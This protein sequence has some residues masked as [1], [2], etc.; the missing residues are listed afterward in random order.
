MQTINRMALGFLLVLAAVTTV[1]GQETLRISVSDPSVNVSFQEMVENQLLISVVDHEEN[2]VLGLNE[3]DFTIKKDGRSTIVLKV[4]P[5]EMAKDVGMNYVLVVDNSF[6]MKER[7]AVEP[8]LSALEK[9]YAILRPIDTVYGIVFNKTPITIDGRPVHAKIFKSGNVSE[10]RKFFNNSFTNKLS[11]KTFLNEAMFAGIELVEKM[12]AVNNKFLVVFS[13][14]EDI[15]SGFDSAVVSEKAEGIAN[16]EA[17]AIDYMPGPDLDPFLKSF[18]EAHGGKIWKASSA[19]DL[20]PIFQAFS[21]KL[22]HRYVVTYRMLNAPSATVEMEPS[23]LSIE[24]VT[25]I[26]SS[27]L[28]NYV[29]FETGQVEIPNRYILFSDQR[30]ANTFSEEAL[31]GTMEKYQNVLNIIGK[32]MTE[33]PDAKLTLIGCNSNMGEEKGNLDLSKGRAEAVRAYLRYMWGI[34]PSRLDVNVQNLPNRP[35]TNATPEGQAENRRVEIYSDTLSVLDVIKSNYVQEISETQEIRVRPE[36]EA[37]TGIKDWKVSLLGEGS[38][39]D[40]KTGKGRPNA[41]Y[42]FDVDTIGLDSIAAL[43]QVTAAIELVDDEGGR[44]EQ[45]SAAAIPVKVIR[46]KE[47]MAQKLGYRV[48]EKYA[49]ILFDFDSSEIK[50]RNKLVIDEIIDRLNNIDS[51]NLKIVGHTDNIGEPDYNVKLSERRAN[52]V[53]K[54]MKAEGIPSSIHVTPK[55]SGPFEPLYDNDSPEGRSL[56]RTVTVTIEYDQGP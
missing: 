8:L 26:D 39:L 12:P 41:L 9:F 42:T 50:D 7:K 53:Y 46:R 56:N 15:N 43:N 32:R 20:I 38:V 40:S 24:E 16:F 21:T 3:M 25:T 55:G 36:I 45:N 34:N 1:F 37:E 48:M 11:D 13:D 30:Q 35:S 5:L 44:Y 23:A 54:K 10:L 2:P 29:F 6:S 27:P 51:A 14:G 19:S 33:N 18:A 17:Y 47:L 28:L 22:L 4:E 52:A 31:R 49:L